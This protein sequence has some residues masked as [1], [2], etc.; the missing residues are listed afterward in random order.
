MKSHSKL[1]VAKSLVIMVCAALFSFS[2]KRGGDS[3]EIVLNGKR[4]L[5]QFVY[6]SKGVQTIQLTPTSDN[7]KLDIYYNHCGQ[8]GKNRYITVKNEKDQPVKIWKFADAVDKN[9]AMSFKLKDILSLR[10]NKTE[11]LNLFYSSSELP[12][13]RTLAVIAGEETGI[14]RK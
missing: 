7:D 9:G 10:K 8:V 14:A 1:I 12:A 5:Q 13:G 4:V 11:K 6:A 2:S 3:F